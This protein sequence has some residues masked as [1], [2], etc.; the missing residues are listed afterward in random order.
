MPLRL[1]SNAHLSST[2]KHT[3][4]YFQVSESGCKPM[5]TY[6]AMSCWN[7]WYLLQS[8]YA[9]DQATYYLWMFLSMY[10]DNQEEYKNKDIA[11]GFN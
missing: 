9:S 11:G 1:Q 7:Y 2:H 5:R 8:K 3:E 6:S 10:E 4:I